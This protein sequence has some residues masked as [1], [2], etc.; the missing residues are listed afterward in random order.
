[1]EFTDGTKGEKTALKVGKLADVIHVS[2][3]SFWVHQRDKE[4]KRVS[5]RNEA[6]G[7]VRRF[8]L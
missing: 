4:S 1:V 6:E 3:K 7:E 2:P 8:I 5:Q